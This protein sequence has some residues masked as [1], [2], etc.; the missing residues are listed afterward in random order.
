ML[1]VDH[2]EEL[3][4][5]VETSSSARDAINK[6]KLLKDK[7]DVAIVDFGLPD[8]KG[9]VLV[10]E[11]RAIRSDL[12]IVIASGYNDAALRDKFAKDSR[13]TFVGKPYSRDDLNAAI[14]SLRRLPK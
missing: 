3:G 11:L 10:S 5:R 1:A 8:L 7:I 2:L 9:D 13:V 14:A 6:I 12:P 4:Y